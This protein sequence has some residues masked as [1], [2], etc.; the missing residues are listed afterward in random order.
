MLSLVGRTGEPKVILRHFDGIFIPPC[1]VL[2]I[3]SILMIGMSPLTLTSSTSMSSSVSIGEITPKEKQSLM[4]WEHLT[5][6][7]PIL[8]I[9]RSSC[10]DVVSKELSSITIIPRLKLGLMSLMVALLKDVSFRIV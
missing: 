5:W 9:A 1:T 10:I 4:G 6:Y 8:F 2:F 3:L 7:S